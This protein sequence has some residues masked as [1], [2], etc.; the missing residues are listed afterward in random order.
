MK[1][2]VFFIFCNSHL[3]L[4][5]YLT[6]CFWLPV[7]NQVDYERIH[8]EFVN[9]P[10]KSGQKYHRDLALL[11]QN[12][13]EYFGWSVDG[14]SVIE[15][16]LAEFNVNDSTF[17]TSTNF[18]LFTD[19]KMN[20]SFEWKKCDTVVLSDVVQYRRTQ[21][22]LIYDSISDSSYYGYLKNGTIYGVDYEHNAFSYFLNE[23]LYDIY[24]LT[25]Q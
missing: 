11:I 10:L 5:T 15:N 12:E 7:P 21:A 23:T 1:L 3:S 13:E 20:T 4:A 25:K 16:C 14:F 24:F 18:R 9:S 8:V 19:Y 22:V 17:L 6:D 2:I